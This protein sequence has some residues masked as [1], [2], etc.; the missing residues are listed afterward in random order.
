MLG[1]S[2]GVEAVRNIR[3]DRTP[4]TRSGTAGRARG[5]DGCPDG[6]LASMRG[7]RAIAGS[8]KAR[9]G[10]LLRLGGSLLVLAAALAAGLWGPRARSA[11]T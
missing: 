9:G 10:R 1:T 7:F 6:I 8:A 3:A 2:G 4:S 5:P 11:R